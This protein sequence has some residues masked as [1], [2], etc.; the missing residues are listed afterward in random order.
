MAPGVRGAVLRFPIEL[1]DSTKRGLKHRFTHAFP[2]IARL[3]GLELEV[4]M[5]MH[6]AT[7][8]ELLCIAS[9]HHTTALLFRTA[10][11]PLH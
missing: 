1:N 9:L 8:Q 10:A 5:L 4:L 6:L 2:F 3:S 11:G 7:W